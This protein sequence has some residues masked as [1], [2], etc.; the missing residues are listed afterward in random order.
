ML[1][2]LADAAQ[3]E[4]DILQDEMGFSTGQ[5]G[6]D[7][8]RVRAM[9]STQRKLTVSK[10]LQV[11]RHMPGSRPTPRRRTCRRSCRRTAGSPPSAA[12]THRA[13]R[14]WRSRRSR[15]VSCPPRC[16]VTG[17]GPGDPQPQGRRA[18]GRGRQRQVLRQG[19]LRLCQQAPQAVV[20]QCSAMQRGAGKCKASF[21][22][23]PRGMRDTR[24]APARTLPPS[25]S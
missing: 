9:Q 4:E 7:T 14:Q 20:V 16:R 15:R 13:W 2:A 23:G 25:M 24:P 12:P 19:V 22:S 5:L 6:A 11:A 10:K 17:A 1:P 8:G 18:E 21:Q 3:V